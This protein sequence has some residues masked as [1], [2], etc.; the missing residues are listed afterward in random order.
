[1]F[2]KTNKPLS[3]V[4]T[5]PAGWNQQNTDRW[6]FGAGIWK[7]S[8][9]HTVA[10]WN[11]FVIKIQCNDDIVIKFEL[12]MNIA[13]KQQTVQQVNLRYFYSFLLCVVLSL[14]GTTRN[15]VYLLCVFFV[16]FVG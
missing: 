5:I 14:T 11:E 9:S 6:I 12:C 15:T 1:M 13:A 10:Q 2:D 16:L 7:E 3:N 4:L 8:M